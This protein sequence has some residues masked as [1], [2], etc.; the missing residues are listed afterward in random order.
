V[1]ERPRILL[2]VTLAETGGAQTYVA[3]LAH[4]LSPEFDVT[5]AAHGRGP[6][7]DAAARAGA[8]YVPLRHV[9]R[10]ISVWRDALGLLEL[11]ILM[12][13]LSP[14]IVHANS[15]KAGILGR[16]AAWL[17]RV[18]IRIFTA[19]GWA[20]S[21]AA[22]SERLLYL[23][24]ERLARPLTSVTICV[25]EAERRTGIAARTCDSRTSL[26][27]LNGVDVTS[28]P[29]ARPASVPPVLV[30]VGRLQTPKDQLTLVRALSELRD[31][32]FRAVLV[33][34]GPDRSSLQGE[35][36]RLGLARKVE[37]AGEQSGVCDLLAAAHV[38]VLASRSEALPLS[39]LEAMAARLPVV[40]SRVGGVP[41]IVVEG[42]T[43][44]LVPPGDPS[45][46]ARALRRL[47]D[48]PH[49]RQRLG[50]AGRVRVEA[51][52]RL[53]VSLGAHLDLYR[54]ELAGRGLPAPRP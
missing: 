43:G 12:R 4:A 6:L 37:L 42:E 47:L 41:E 9:R 52:F 46:L 3:G 31:R 29:R 40:A 17:A 11:L 28:R 20:F 13:R 18:P 10:S 49:L 35:V 30:T 39:V 21:A 2:L 14:H 7:V 23:W 51:H 16:V 48:D 36:A 24:A 33:G 53:D 25:S 45:S 19:H 15:S 50:A 26:V 5:V 22:G 34:E 54:R 44:F 38:F 1:R 27:V 8:R 32:D